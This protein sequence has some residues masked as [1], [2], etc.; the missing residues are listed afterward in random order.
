MHEHQ[1][2]KPVGQRKPSSLIFRVL[3][4]GHVPRTLSLSLPLSLSL[5]RG[6]SWDPKARKPMVRSQQVGVAY[7]RSLVMLGVQGLRPWNRPNPRA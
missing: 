3:T 5:S 6:L 4:L 7:D 2:C 1:R